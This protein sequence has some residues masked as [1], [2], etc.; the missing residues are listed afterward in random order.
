MK[1][2]LTRALLRQQVG[3]QQARDRD[4][5]EGACWRCGAYL[6]L[7]VDGMG[8][9]RCRDRYA[10]LRRRVAQE[11]PGQVCGAEPEATGEERTVTR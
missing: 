5:A 6:G 8:W 2:P 7:E 4:N 1:W 11:Q 3:E 10:C 9:L